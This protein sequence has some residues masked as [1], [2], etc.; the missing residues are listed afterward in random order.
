MWNYLITV[1]QSISW[2]LI[3]TLQY[4]HGISGSVEVVSVLM[5]INSVNLVWEPK[6]SV[7]TFLNC[8]EQSCSTSSIVSI[9]KWNKKES[10]LRIEKQYSYT[11]C[12]SQS[13]TRIDWLQYSHGIFVSMISSSKPLK[14][15]KMI[16]TFFL[17]ITV[18]ILFQ[19]FYS[20]FMGIST[21]FLQFN[22]WWA[23]I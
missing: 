20:L 10:K 15:S 22:R 23:N 5:K 4:S 11:K 8:L 7:C 1:C 18:N 3:G 2:I 6:K 9:I 19:L 17:F 12:R 13:C 21:L 16:M 14:I